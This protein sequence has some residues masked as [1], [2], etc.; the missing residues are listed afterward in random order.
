MFILKQKTPTPKEGL[1]GVPTKLLII[2]YS[3]QQTAQLIMNNHSSYMFLLQ[4][5]T[6]TMTLSDRC[7][8]RHKSTANSVQ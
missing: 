4:V 2:Q 6:S 5:S 7:I 3:I 8:Q 1:T